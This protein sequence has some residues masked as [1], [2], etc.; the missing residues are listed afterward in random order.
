[1]ENESESTIHLASVPGSPVA[2][3]L[4]SKDANRQAMEWVDLQGHA[5]AV[6]AIDGGARMTLPSSVAGQVEDLVR[7]ESACCSFLDITMA[8]H[9]D[10]LTLD[11][12]STNPDAQPVIA[13]LSG[14]AVT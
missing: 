13:A 12:S 4:T 8:I 6:E 5:T 3:T 7:R 2:C 9:Q 10:E 14:V 11:V 1:M